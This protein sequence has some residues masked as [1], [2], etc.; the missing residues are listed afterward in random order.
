MQII[1][2]PTAAALAY[3]MGKN[4]GLSGKKVIIFDLGGGT[5][6]VSLLHIT[7]GI[8]KVLATHGDPHLG[9]D[10]FDEKIVRF[11]L[12]E[13]KKKTGKDATKNIRAVQRL[14]VEAE[15]AKR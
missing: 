2:E 10:D 1:N 14:R 9:G 5:F 13:F 3:G 11:L 8:F 7:P 15:I 4:V 6:D 12:A